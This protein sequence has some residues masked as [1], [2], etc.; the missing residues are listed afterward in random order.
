MKNRKDVSAKDGDLILIEYSEEHPALVSNVGMASKIVNYYK[1]KANETR[2]KFRH[3][4]LV[5]VS[6]NEKTMV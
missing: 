3:G 2:P 4:S 5:T 1:K 6:K